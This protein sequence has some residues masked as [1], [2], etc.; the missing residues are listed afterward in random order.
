M[1]AFFFGGASNDPVAHY[2]E[3]P[4]FDARRQVS[5]MGVLSE[6]FRRRPGVRRSLHPTHSICAVG[7][8]AGELV[9]GHHLAPT[10]FGPGTPFAVMAARHTVILGIG[11]EYFRNLTQ[12][13]AVEDLLGDRFPLR[14]SPTT[15][16]V[17]LEDVNGTVHRY[18][19]P[20]QD[21]ALRR[22]PIRLGHLLGPDE[23]AQWTFHG[24]PL[25]ATT[26]AGV[27]EA[28]IAAALRGE[29]I[30]DALPIRPTA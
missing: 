11:T 29:T 18:E 7:P 2:R 17:Q 20:I 9:E 12:V 19:L 15:L 26:A 8:L 13:R 25:F 10:T 3:Q 1:P 24:V 6:A 14:V 21:R 4:R 27:T 5:E 16:P 23:L 22:Q 30:Y 28:L